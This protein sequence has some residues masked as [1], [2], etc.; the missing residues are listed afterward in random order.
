MD[1]LEHSGGGCLVDQVLSQTSLIQG[2]RSKADI[3]AP[4]P[5]GWDLKLHLDDQKS[6]P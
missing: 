1:L 2:T 5:A 6:D 3:S 4:S